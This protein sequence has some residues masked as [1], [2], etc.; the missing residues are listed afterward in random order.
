MFSGLFKSLG[1]TLP[2]PTRIL[3]ALSQGLKTFFPVL[4]VVFI[5]GMVGWAKI[6]HEERVIW[7]ITAAI[8]RSSRS[9][10]LRSHTARDPS[11]DL[12]FRP[13]LRLPWAA[14][15]RQGSLPA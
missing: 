6:R 7:G 11:H 5:A 13:V 9:A 4:L 12:R 3:V 15:G 10:V 2:L 8:V 14:A 1:G